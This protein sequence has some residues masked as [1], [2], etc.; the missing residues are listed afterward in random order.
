M[1][2]MKN[3]YFCI[4][5]SGA[6]D[7]EQ[8]LI[9]GVL[10]K[11]TLVKDAIAD[12]VIQRV[13]K[14]YLPQKNRYLME[15]DPKG[16]DIDMEFHH[17]TQ[18]PPSI[19]ADVKIKML[20]AIHA[21][22]FRFVIF[23][24]ASDFSVDNTTETYLVVLAQG[25]VKLMR[26]L[27]RQ[28]HF[29]GE[30]FQLHLV[31]GDRVDT[32]KKNAGRLIPRKD[33]PYL[34]QQDDVRMEIKKA[35]HV[36]QAMTPDQFDRD[37][38]LASIT[39]ASDKN[40]LRLVLSDYVANSWQTQRTFRGKN[41]ERFETKLKPCYHILKMEAQSY[42]DSIRTAIRHR[43][44]PQ[45]LLLA[46]DAPDGA[47]DRAAFIEELADI[48]RRMPEL[49]LR[50]AMTAYI[51]TFE[52]LINTHR[53]YHQVLRI[54]D[55]TLAHFAKATIMHSYNT[56]F[57]A[58]LYLWKM[59][60]CTHLGDLAGYRNAQMLCD[61]CVRATSDLDL[62]LIYETYRVG[63]LRAQ[64]L[65]DESYA[66]GKEAATIIQAFRAPAKAVKEQTGRSFVLFRDRYAKLC[67]ALVSTCILMAPG[68]PEAYDYGCYYSNQAIATF[69]NQR[70]KDRQYQLRADLA[71]ASGKYDEAVHYLERA[72]HIQMDALDPE[73]AAAFRG[74]D[75][76]HFAKVL[77]CLLLADD[78]HRALAKK[79]FENAK[80]AW[81][82]YYESLEKLAFPDYVSLANL[83]ACYAE[84]GFVD[85]GMHMM[86]MAYRAAYGLRFQRSKSKPYPFLGTP[87]A[88]EKPDFDRT[89][90]VVFVIGLMEQ[91]MYFAA[92]ALRAP[93]TADDLLPLRYHVQAD[94]EH[95]PFD[96]IKKRLG[97]FDR[98]LQEIPALADG[99]LQHDRLWALS[100]TADF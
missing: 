12:G 50:T 2:T 48:F 71:A 92:Q 49:D 42:Y 51:R 85:T 7:G 20:E 15:K 34:I 86:R 94:M 28:A 26:E 89:T 74:Y 21:A 45:A 19:K 47:A 78:A 25:V 22:G 17:A 67:G 80:R 9:G 40:N 59:A 24:P 82:L 6:F 43:D 27:S 76:Y 18:L 37:S 4:D 70:D 54:L 79:A 95:W 69:S 63:N 81:K 55:Q 64:L 83:G 61:E 32:G 23:E 93:L 98:A 38:S 65:Y 30:H 60:A 87:V 53:A 33:R 11:E 90:P 29:T 58:N 100:R 14:P 41:R 1:M 36:A 75:W 5:E 44:Y 46:V 8:S 13:R 68:V 35:L 77:A 3:Y 10:C 16:R 97:A 52:S 56:E 91:A 84:T 39:F 72:L 62:Y 73:R 57:K 96:G 88:E 31:I 66:A 99:K